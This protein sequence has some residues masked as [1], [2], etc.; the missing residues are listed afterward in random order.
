[1][2]TKEGDV[3]EQHYNAWNSDISL[4]HAPRELGDGNV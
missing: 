2:F 3:T 4:L 1:M